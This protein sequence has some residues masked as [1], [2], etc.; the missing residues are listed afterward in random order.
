ME[1]RTEL[2][3]PS[4]ASAYLGFNKRNRPLRKSVVLQYAKDMRAGKWELHHQGIA[5]NCDGT[6]LDGQHRLAAVIESQVSV[7][8]LV[9]RG[10]S[11]SAQLTMDDHAKRTAADAIGLA[12]GKDYTN[13]HVAIVR[14]CTEI[15]GSTKTG[16]KGKKTKNEL[17]ELL[18]VFQGP[19]DF[20]CD[21]ITGNDKGVGSAPVMAAVCMAWF[22]VYELDGLEKF[23][24]VLTGKEMADG[25]GD[26]AA[27][28]LRE[29]LLRN[30]MLHGGRTY[31]VEVFKKTQ[32]AIYAFLKR[33]P[34]SKLYGGDFLY[35]WPLINPV[36]GMER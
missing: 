32:R 19:F 25:E 4:L 9:T 31:R 15:N 7:P 12:H 2:I 8:M 35:P 27:I 22:Y 26:K 21:L 20:V 1:S 11:E 36:R 33:Q 5:F 3:T 30:G 29:F 24:L 10:V 23:C 34:L 13:R 28:T 16:T 17:S 6:L 18:S 14:C